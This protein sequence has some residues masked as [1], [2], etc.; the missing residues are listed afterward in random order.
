[1]AEF[2]FILG[3]T[4]FAIYAGLRIARYVRT[5]SK[6]RADARLKDHLKWSRHTKKNSW[7]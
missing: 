2:T 6:R 7:V 4:I 5:E 3:G 1:M